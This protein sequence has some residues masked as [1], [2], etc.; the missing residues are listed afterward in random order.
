[1]DSVLLDSVSLDSVSLA[2]ARWDS[3]AQNS[4]TVS[5]LIAPN[6]YITHDKFGKQ[7]RVIKKPFTTASYSRKYSPLWTAK[8]QRAATTAT[9]TAVM[10]LFILVSFRFVS[11][12]FCRRNQLVQKV[13]G[14]GR[15]YT[16]RYLPDCASTYLKINPLLAKATWHMYYE[17]Y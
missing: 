17:T 12:R 14:A 13:I 2:L 5:N 6:S 9:E 16:T 1:V 3:V 8:M 10:K 4:V 11:F 15:F 7:Q